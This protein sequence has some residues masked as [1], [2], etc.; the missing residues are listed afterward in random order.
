MEGIDMSKPVNYIHIRDHRVAKDGKMTVVSNGGATIGYI[1][2]G[3]KVLYTVSRCNE[4]DVFCRRIGR[5]ISRGR[6]A[7]EKDCK[8][9][10]VAP[11]IFRGALR[12]KLLDDYYDSLEQHIPDAHQR[13]Y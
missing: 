12:A 6:L 10:N 4:K 1:L 5:A 3:T 13:L 8:V 9:I 7:K 11:D 2:D